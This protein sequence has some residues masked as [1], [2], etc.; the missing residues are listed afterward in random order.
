MPWLIATKQQDFV[1][2]KAFSL[3]SIVVY[4]S[5]VLPHWVFPRD[6][7]QLQATLTPYAYNLKL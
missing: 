3:T 7:V 1:T 5:K 4:F 6:I 2:F